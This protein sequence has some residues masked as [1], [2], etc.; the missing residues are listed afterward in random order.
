MK[1]LLTKFAG[2]LTFNVFLLW[3]ILKGS[4]FYIAQQHFENWETE[5]NLLFLPHHQ[6]YDWTVLGA[7]H[8]RELTRSQNHLLV[9][10]IL[11]IK[12]ANL[13]QGRGR[14]GI[15]NQ[16]LYLRYFY[17]TGNSTSKIVYFLDPSLVFSTS[18]DEVSITFDS[19]P[20]EERFFALNLWRGSDNYVQQLYQYARSKMTLEWLQTSPNR[21]NGNYD[22]LSQFD[23]L[24]VLRGIELSYVDGFNPTILESNT[25]LLKELIEM[26]VQHHSEVVFLIPPARFGKWKGHEE[27]I[28][29]LKNLTESHT[30]VAY[31]DFSEAYLDNCY[32]YDHHHLNTDGVIALAYE[33]LGI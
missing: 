29:M 11:D 12:M 14:G 2:L 20:F 13:A 6:D 4:S 27:T 22:C 25:Q 1:K 15:R 17:D 8:A 21:K 7:S 33:L 31:H 18:W 24:K 30:N 23:S 26:A 10:D 28:S 16:Y 5:S 19:E 3:V 9:E 32:Y